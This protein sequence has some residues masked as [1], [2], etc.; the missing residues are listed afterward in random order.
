MGNK[1]KNPPDFR[2]LFPILFIEREETTT[3][4]TDVGFFLLQTR[5]DS[6]GFLKWSSVCVCVYSKRC[7][8][9]KYLYKN[10]KGGL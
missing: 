2:D 6:P 4:T 1:T 8:N 9:N 10:N 5:D 3:T 7:N